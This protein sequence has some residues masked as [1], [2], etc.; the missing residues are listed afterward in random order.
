MGDGYSFVVLLFVTEYLDF[1]HSIIIWIDGLSLSMINNW[2]I[3]WIKL[4]KH[5]HWL[6]S[7]ED[8]CAAMEKSRK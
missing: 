7:H 1:V 6:V 3:C 8:R 5:D 2:G 4:D